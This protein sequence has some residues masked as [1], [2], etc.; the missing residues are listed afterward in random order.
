MLLFSFFTPSYMK[1]FIN[2]K[3]MPCFT[4]CL[5]VIERKTA[6]SIIRSYMESRIHTEVDLFDWFVFISLCLHTS[7]QCSYVLT[8]SRSF[9]FL[10]QFQML[11][12]EE[13]KNLH[14]SYF[15]IMFNVHMSFMSSCQDFLIL[16]NRVKYF[17]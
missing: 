8:P 10:I 15:Y 16:Q 12:K 5:Q 4:I 3:C 1:S 17:I 13:I 2:L 7:T 11:N 9:F 6:P 14:A